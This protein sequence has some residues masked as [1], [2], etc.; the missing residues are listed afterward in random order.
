MNDTVLVRML[1]GFADLNHQLQSLPGVQAMCFGVLPERVAANEL[2]REIGLRPE[3]RI[4]RA[5]FI[6][7]SY[8]GVLQPAE[9]LRLMFKPS[10]QFWSGAAG[11][12][13]LKSYAAARLFLFRFIDGPHAAFAQ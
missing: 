11:L 12:D 7:L 3:T 1:H 8:T 5:G 2:H 13:Y 10:Q 4:R 9:R 6:D